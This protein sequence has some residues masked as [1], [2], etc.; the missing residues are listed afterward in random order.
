MQRVN[1]FW[2]GHVRTNAL[3]RGGHP[4]TFTIVIIIIDNPGACLQLPGMRP[5]SAGFEKGGTMRIHALCEVSCGLRV[6]GL[7]R[8]YGAS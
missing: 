4:K 8:C 2:A 1:I 5:K 6:A 7:P 3:A